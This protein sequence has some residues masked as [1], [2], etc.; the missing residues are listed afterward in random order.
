M[1]AS[2]SLFPLYPFKDNSHIHLP[3]NLRFWHQLKTFMPFSLRQFFPL[4]FHNVS[5]PYDRFVRVFSTAKLDLIN[6]LL[7]QG[8]ARNASRFA[9]F[10]TVPAFANE[11]L[12]RQTSSN[13]ETNESWS[14]SLLLSSSIIF[15]PQT[16]MAGS[17][18]SS[19]SLMTQRCKPSHNALHELVQRS[20]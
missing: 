14:A 12:P 19:S 13:V 9:I 2:G 20:A 11:G 6:A 4:S 1:E 17:S 16:S 15:L 8:E 5:V 3:V 7:L 10:K 18:R